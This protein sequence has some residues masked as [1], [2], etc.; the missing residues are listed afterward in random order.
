MNFKNTEI[1]KLKQNIIDAHNLFLKAVGAP[2][3]NQLQSQCGYNF[4]RK[5]Q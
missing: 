5:G 1:I 4:V 2:S 3:P